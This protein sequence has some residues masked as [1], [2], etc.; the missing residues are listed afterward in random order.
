MAQNKPKLSLSGGK[1]STVDNGME[2]MYK[3]HKTLENEIEENDEVLMEKGEEEDFIEEL[4]SW[5][6][7]TLG[8]R[9]E[10]ERREAERRKEQ[11]KGF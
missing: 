11:S 6:N 8:E 7:L 3:G 2:H 1:Q 10:E 4:A 5:G 9:Q